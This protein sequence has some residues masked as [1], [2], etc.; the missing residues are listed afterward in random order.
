M[1]VNNAGILNGDYVIIATGFYAPIMRGDYPI[2]SWGLSDYVARIIGDNR[3][4][5]CDNFVT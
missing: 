2:M 3:K 5:N 4:G 1:V